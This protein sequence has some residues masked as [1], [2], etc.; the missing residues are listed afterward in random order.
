MWS[1]ICICVQ[2]TLALHQLQKGQHKSLL[3]ARTKL[4][5]TN[6]S[7]SHLGIYLLGYFVV[8]ILQQDYKTV[9]LLD[10]L[11]ALAYSSCARLMTI[12]LSIPFD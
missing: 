10:K 7:T 12:W 8:R 3:R 5:A 1:S 6:V 9:Y 11:V 4:M 2:T